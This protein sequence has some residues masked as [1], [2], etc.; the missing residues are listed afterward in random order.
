AALMLRY[1]FDMENEATKIEEAIRTVLKKGL[2]TGDIAEPGA[3][4]IG[5]EEMGKAIVQSL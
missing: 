4:V 2:R 5:T 3:Q 1:S